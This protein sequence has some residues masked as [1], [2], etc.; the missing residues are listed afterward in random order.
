MNDTPASAS[1][2]K[3]LGAW[4]TNGP[5]GELLRITGTGIAVCLA[6]RGLHHRTRHFRHPVLGGAGN[7]PAVG[8]DDL[9]P[10]I[11][12]TACDK[13]CN[14]KERARERQISEHRLASG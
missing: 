5:L 9:I 12:N 6:R 14:G 2:V 10:G 13:R 3:A 1:Y 11:G 7:G 8:I 4:W